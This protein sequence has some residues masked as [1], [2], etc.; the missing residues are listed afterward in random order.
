MD[1]VTPYSADIC[2]YMNS[3]HSDALTYLAAYHGDVD[4]T[5]IKLESVDSRGFVLKLWIPGAAVK[6]IKIE[7][8]KPVTDQNQATIMLQQMAQDSRNAI[9]HSSTWFEM[10]K[11]I[12]S[13]L[14]S[15]SIGL[16]IYSGYVANKVPSFLV[17]LLGDRATVETMRRVVKLVATI[18]LLESIAVFIVCMRRRYTWLTTF[19]W[20]LFSFIVGAP[21]SLTV[22]KGPSRALK[23][24]KQ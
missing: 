2:Q 9:G 8:K 22:F 12:P 16:L 1:P 4:S 14:I 21:C 11:A 7:F 3:T 13:L 24:K 6:R 5:S 18:H 20:V 23:T 10:P 17:A 15:A 19:K